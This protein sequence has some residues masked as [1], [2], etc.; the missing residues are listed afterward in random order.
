MAWGAQQDE[1][2]TWA[3]WIGA[4]RSTAPWSDPRWLAFAPPLLA[5]W[6]ATG[7]ASSCDAPQAGRVRYEF[8]AARW[9]T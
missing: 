8:Y 2:N 6:R 1:D 3:T 9:Q 4:L 5:S 7:V